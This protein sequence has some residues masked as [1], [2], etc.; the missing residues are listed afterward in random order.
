MSTIT[1]VTG[2]NQGI[3]LAVA[4]TL[5]KGH[6]HHVLVGSRNK[7]AGKD[8]AASLRDAGHAATGIQLDLNDDKSIA[9]AVETIRQDFGHLDVLV[10]NAG[11]LI[12][13]KIKEQSA[14]DLFT[15]TM[16]TNVVG[17]AC[18]TEALLPLLR[19]SEKP[20]VVFVSS[21]MG[22]LHQAT[23]KNTMFYATD[24]K[25]YDA[26]KAAVNMLALNYARILEDISTNLNGY[27]PYGG[28]V[29]EG[30]RRIVELAAGTKDGDVT[31]TFSDRDGSIAW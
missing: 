10:N 26:S 7:A 23:V 20:R 29:E 25:A 4:T 11:I 19:T 17:T 24:Y 8:I 1:L 22:S 6:G 16:S 2:A 31:R 9:A 15:Q 21:R 18:L 5:A 14:R 12:D 30:A 28:T 27:T 3:G 13:G